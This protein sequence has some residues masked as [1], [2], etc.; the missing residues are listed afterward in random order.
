ML[1]ETTYFTV[2]DTFAQNVSKVYCPESNGALQR[3]LIK[4]VSSKNCLT[5]VSLSAK[6]KP[7][8]NVRCVI[9][10]LFIS[11]QRTPSSRLL[12]S[13]ETIRGEEL[14]EDPQKLHDKE[15]FVLVPGFQNHFRSEG[16]EHKT[17]FVI[18]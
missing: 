5:T 14:Y 3:S 12:S 4:N 6:F 13:T 2:S 15:P 11:P 7:A 16:T 9:N 17:I 1:S 8:T 10:F 18:R